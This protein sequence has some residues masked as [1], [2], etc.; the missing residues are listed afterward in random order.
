MFNFFK[1]E[2]DCNHDWQPLIKTIIEPKNTIFEDDVLARLAFTGA[3]TYVF[4]C[5]VCKAVRKETC[6]G[7]ETTTLE[8]LLDK[9][10]I[11]GPEYLGREG[12][13]YIIMRKPDQPMIKQ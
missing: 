11:G 8:R 12:K 3:T 1:R 9:V 13:T 4:Q 2:P 10:D 5:A 7:V 6:E